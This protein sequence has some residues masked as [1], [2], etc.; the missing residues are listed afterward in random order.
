MDDPWQEKQPKNHQP[1]DAIYRSLAS[2]EKTLES[3]RRVDLAENGR[4]S[5]SSPSGWGRIEAAFIA[6]VWK[7]PVL[8][9]TRQVYLSRRQIA[10]APRPGNLLV[11]PLLSRPGAFAA[12]VAVVN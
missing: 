9:A 5:V 11:S 12:L 8:I 1:L 6:P 4:N 2:Q 7:S 3:Q 10:S